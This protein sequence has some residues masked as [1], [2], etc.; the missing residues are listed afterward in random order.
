MVL[1]R[2]YIRYV[3]FDEI[4]PLVLIKFVSTKKTLAICYGKLLKL[5]SIYRA[6]ETHSNKDIFLI[7]AIN[8]Y[9]ARQFTVLY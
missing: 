4:L 9:E 2:T 7:R 8:I 1:Y 3:P 6:K 5:T